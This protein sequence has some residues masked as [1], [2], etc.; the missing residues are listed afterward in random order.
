MVKIKVYRKLIWIIG[1]MKWLLSGI[2]AGY[3]IFATGMDAALA[4]CYRS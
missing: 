1:I 4:A 3:G 2:Y